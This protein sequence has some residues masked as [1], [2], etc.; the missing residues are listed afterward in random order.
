MS[1]KKC[2]LCFEL[3]IRADIKPT[4]HPPSGTLLA[5]L[6]ASFYDHILA[7]VRN[8]LLWGTDGFFS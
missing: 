8:S 1:Q 5:F 7:V 2:N 6:I 3:K 4:P